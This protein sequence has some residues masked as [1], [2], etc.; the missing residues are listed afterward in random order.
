MTL[1]SPSLLFVVWIVYFS[2]VIKVVP[3]DLLILISQLLPI[4]THFCDFKS[5]SVL[6][7]SIIRDKRDKEFVV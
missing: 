1:V 4:L 6:W 5:N 7:M 3:A 2:L